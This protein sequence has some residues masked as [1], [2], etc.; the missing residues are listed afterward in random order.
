[1]LGTKGPAESRPSK[2]PRSPTPSLRGRGRATWTESSCGGRAR[3]GDPLRPRGPAREPTH[4]RG[5]RQGAA[6][7]PE[8]WRLSR[9]RTTGRAGRNAGPVTASRA[10]LA[11]RAD[12]SPP[13]LEPPAAADGKN[14]SHRFETATI[15]FRCTSREA[16]D[17]ASTRASR[18]PPPGPKE[19]FAVS[20]VSAAATPFLRRIGSADQR[21]KDQ[22]CVKAI[23]PT[24]GLQGRSDAAP[25]APSPDRRRARADVAVILSLFARRDDLARPR[26]PTPSAVFASGSGVAVSGVITPADQA[27]QR[28][29]QASTSRSRVSERCS[30]TTLTSA[31]TGMKFVSPPQR[32]TT[33]WWMWSTTPAP[34]ARPRFQPRL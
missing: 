9:A 29:G 13:E 16:T 19:Q 28:D 3:S 14:E 10:L 18:K 12:G 32:G 11:C 17:R 4:L 15:T 30:G 20:P 25:R 24:A 5:R 6:E 1:L 2:A 23:E 26:G 7:T 8:W 27:D 21:S 33:C 31:S 22:C 34:A